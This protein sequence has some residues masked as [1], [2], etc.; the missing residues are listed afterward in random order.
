MEENSLDLFC[1]DLVIFERIQSMV[2]YGSNVV[3]YFW[4]LRLFYLYITQLTVHW[5]NIIRYMIFEDIDLQ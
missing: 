2:E 4:R 5:Y 1:F 3:G